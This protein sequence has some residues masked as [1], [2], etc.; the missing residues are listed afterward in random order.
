MLGPSPGSKDAHEDESCDP[1]EEAKLMN[2]DAENKIDNL[3]K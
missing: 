2:V 3:S 1:E